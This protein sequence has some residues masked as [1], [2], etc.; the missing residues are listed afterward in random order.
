[1]KKYKEYLLS[2]DNFKNPVLKEG[3]DATGLLIMRLLILDPG[4]NRRHPSMG[5]GML[6]KLFSSSSDILDLQENID[7][8]MNTYMPRV[9]RPSEI[10]LTG[11]KKGFLEIHIVVK[12]IDYIYETENTSNPI[13][14]KDL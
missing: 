6:S 2:T 9:I 11:N 1:M 14:I 8:Q 12:D 5:I 4:T 3:N 10:K 7:S 13:S